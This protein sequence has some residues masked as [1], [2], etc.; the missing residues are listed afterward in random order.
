MSA[1]PGAPAASPDP[2]GGRCYLSFAGED[3][4]H[5]SHAHADLQ[6]MVQIARVR[7]VLLVNTLGMR[8]VVGGHQPSG[9]TVRRIVRRLATMRPRSVHP[10]PALLPRFAVLAPVVLPFYGPTVLGR[11]NV[12]LVAFQVRRALRREGLRRPATL[13]ANPMAWPVT[14]RLGLE[15]VAYYR[16]DHQS[17]TPGVDRSL[18]AGLEQAMFD[19]AALVVYS[20][21]SLLDA[22]AGRHH[23]RARHLDHGVDTVRFDPDRADLA[24]PADLAVIP[25]PRVALVGSLEGATKDVEL[26][27]EVARG[28]PEAN[29]VVIGATADASP[30]LAALPN[31]TF[32]GRKPH[33]EIPAYL[34]HLDVGL[35]LVPSHEWGQGSN[36]IK[37]KEYLAMGLAVV[38]TPFPEAA[39]YG[40]LVRVGDDRAGFVE[41]V[42][43]AV[44]GGAPD[45]VAARRSAGAA[46]SWQDQAVTLLGWWGDP[47]GASEL[48]ALPPLAES[49]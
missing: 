11:L 34:A 29:V 21:S 41:A 8:A 24:E 32:L 2:S 45:D 40:S 28:V 23:G 4:W 38:T 12:A 1:D 43:D 20:A 37:L 27:V 39:R 9:S 49:V 3:W 42:R 14:Q 26:L 17:A 36:P 30:A 22:E 44:H 7:P 48:A 47:A 6:V 5:H 19:R 25:H 13:I 35:V 18:V 16:I 10:A 33:G 31:V 46:R 15:P